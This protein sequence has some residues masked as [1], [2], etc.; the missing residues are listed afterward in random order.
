[1]ADDR[2][3]QLLLEAFFQARSRDG[4]GGEAFRD[5]TTPGSAGFP[6]ALA[7]TTRNLTSLR[8]ANEALAE[9]VVANTRAV[10]QSTSRQGTGPSAAG[11]VGRSLLGTFASGLTLAPLAS[12]LIKLFRG[13]SEEAPQPLPRFVPPAPVR[14]EAANGPLHAGP[15][16]L[17]LADRGQDG[18]PRVVPTHVTVQVQAMDSRSFLEHSHEIARAVRDAMLNMHSL[19]DVITDL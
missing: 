7:D 11:A 4:G 9:A 19:N 15:V 13:G 17:P 2:L 6:E 12:S 14:I 1:M 8:S 5:S 18:S 10:D 16:G 3:Q